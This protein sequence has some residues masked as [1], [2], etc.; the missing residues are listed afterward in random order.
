MCAVQS[1]TIWV[2]TLSAQIAQPSDTTAQITIFLL[3]ILLIVDY[4]LLSITDYIHISSLGG[5]LRTSLAEARPINHFLK[6]IS[7]HVSGP[8]SSR[9]LSERNDW[10]SRVLYLH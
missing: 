3:N 8:Y 6:Q 5:G 10:F 1:A 9:L 7:S 4:S 2:D